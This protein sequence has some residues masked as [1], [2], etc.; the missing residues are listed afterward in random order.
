MKNGNSNERKGNLNLK[1]VQEVA[2]IFLVRQELN[3]VWGGDFWLAGEIFGTPEMISRF[4][5]TDNIL[6]QQAGAG[7]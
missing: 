2:M 4:Y 6:S 5:E 3:L 1:M 7:V